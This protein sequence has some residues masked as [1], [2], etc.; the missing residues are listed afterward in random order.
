[1]HEE[2]FIPGEQHALAQSIVDRR[3]LRKRQLL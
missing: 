3:E 1:M 2:V